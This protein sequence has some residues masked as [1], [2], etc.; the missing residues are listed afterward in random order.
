MFRECTSLTT[1]PELPATIL[2]HLCYSSMFYGCS[3]LSYIKALFI[4]NPTT[5]YTAAWVYN[6]AASGV[7][8]K[9]NNATW[10]VSG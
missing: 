7:F 3:N 6:V 4:T 1:A 8:I 2:S 9:N 10:D 5:Y